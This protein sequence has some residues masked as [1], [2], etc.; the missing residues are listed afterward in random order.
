MFLA[1]RVRV[2]DLLAEERPQHSADHAAVLLHFRR[3]GSSV[4]QGASVTTD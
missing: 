1:D 2:H 4:V 3:R